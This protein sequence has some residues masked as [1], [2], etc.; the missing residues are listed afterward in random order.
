[1]GHR[2]MHK[3]AYNSDLN[4]GSLMVRESRLIAGLLL[5]NASSEEWHLA[6]QID[7][8][9]Q[10]RSPAT[11]RRYAQA[12]RKRLE[13]V[14]PDYW[15]LLRDEDDE[16]ATQVAFYAA[17]E[18]NHLLV[19]FI[20]SVVRDA[21]LTGNKSLASYQ[22][23]EFLEDSALRDPTINN[24]TAATKK[25]MGNVVFRILCEVGYLENSRNLKLQKVIIRTELNT[26]LV[27]H[28]ALHLKAC[29]NVALAP[30]HINPAI[31]K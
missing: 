23:L 5:N 29:M 25:K 20:Q 6:I 18:R 14:A 4:G 8:I 9:L 31:R 21:Y 22:W 15:R 19:E 13:L 16:L 27:A 17:L 3:F 30:H 10:K 24:W 7:N 28:N 12:I 26:L 2:S 11:A 1:M